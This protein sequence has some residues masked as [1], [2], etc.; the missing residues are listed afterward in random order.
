MDIQKYVET[1]YID[2]KKKSFG[3]F[4]SKITNIELGFFCWRYAGT[5]I[6]FFL[7]LYAPGT[8]V[9]PAGSTD[10]HSDDDDEVLSHF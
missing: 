4:Y 6:L 2:F 10:I 5:F 3:F 1:T 8:M 9:G 7:G